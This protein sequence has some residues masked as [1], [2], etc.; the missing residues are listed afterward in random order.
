[1]NVSKIKE[2]AY[3]VFARYAN[4]ELVQCKCERYIDEENCADYIRMYLYY[5]GKWLGYP[6]DRRIRDEIFKRVYTDIDEKNRIGFPVINLVPTEDDEEYWDWLFGD[7]D[8]EVSEARV[9]AERP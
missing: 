7:K 3:E 9:M 1:M 5:P 2:I 6:T 4:R 8:P